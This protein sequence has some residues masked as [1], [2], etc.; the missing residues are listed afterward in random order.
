MQFAHD[1]IR[2]TRASRGS[3][4]VASA[5]HRS[6]NFVHVRS[7]LNS[8]PNHQNAWTGRWWLRERHRTDQEIHFKQLSSTWSAWFL[9]GFYESIRDSKMA[10]RY[11]RDFRK[12]W[13][14]KLGF[15]GQCLSHIMLVWDKL[16]TRVGFLYYFRAQI[17]Q[18]NG[19]KPTTWPWLVGLLP[20]LISWHVVMR[21]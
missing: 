10:Q 7:R 18:Q 19:Q 4:R 5:H 3:G 2:W 17:P 16:D 8:S 11:E 13:L 12:I 21:N 14:G 1:V 15:L 9:S 20:R 6:L